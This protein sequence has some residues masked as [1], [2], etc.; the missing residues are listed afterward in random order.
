MSIWTGIETSIS[1]MSDGPEDIRPSLPIR[2]TPSSR[3]R[4]PRD[5]RSP[6]TSAEPQIKGRR[7]QMTRAELVQNLRYAGAGDR[8]AFAAVYDS[9]S[10]KLY[11]VVFRILK[12]EDVAADVLQDVYLRI[13][14]RL[15]SFDPALSSPMTWLITIARN[16]ALDEVRRRPTTSLDEVSDLLELPAQ[17]DVAR[18][19]EEKEKLARLAMCL[20][21]LEPER[22]RIVLM[23]YYEGLTREEVARRTN[24]PLS[25]VKTWLRR[26]LAS[27]KECLAR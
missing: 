26:S 25:T 9:T 27:M 22:R 20:E 5:W 1:N 7:N 18:E 12:R 23:I 24:Y 4:L 14:L 19:F 8:A 6:M 16:R 2:C 15:K 13:W 11:G 21:R 17:D 10:M 3:S